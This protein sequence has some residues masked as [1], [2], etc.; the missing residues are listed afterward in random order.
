VLGQFSSQFFAK[1]GYTVLQ[2]QAQRHY[3][4]PAS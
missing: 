4:P 2:A 3:V 1:H